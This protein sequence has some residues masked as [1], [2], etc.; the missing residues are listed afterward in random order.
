QRLSHFVGKPSTSAQLGLSDDWSGSLS[1][2]GFG[3]CLSVELFELFFHFP[4]Q[5]IVLG[6]VGKIPGV[7]NVAGV[8]K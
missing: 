4:K 1:K 6:S 8:I 2:D 5:C 7:A 3:Q